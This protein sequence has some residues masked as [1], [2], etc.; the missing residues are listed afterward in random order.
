I[1]LSPAAVLLV[2][3]DGDRIVGFVAAA[4]S[5][6]RLYRDFLRHD[7]VP[8]GLAAAP[9]V[10]RAPRRVWET[11]RYGSAGDDLPAAEVLSIAVAADAEGRGIGGALLVAALEALAEA[12]A[13]AARVVTAVGNDPALA[14]YERA[15]FRR[16][17]RTEVHA[18]VPQE[19]LVWP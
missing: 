4:T 14:M 12:G 5:T 15:G 11:L 2:A 19:V 6:R 7:A 3:E 18:G 9:A 1:A 10:I 16:R 17:T 8:A 13:P